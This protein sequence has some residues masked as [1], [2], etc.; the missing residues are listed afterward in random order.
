MP[1]K[2]KQSKPE[3]IKAK[4][5]RKIEAEKELEEAVLEP[6]VIERIVYKKPRV[7]GFFRTL[8]IL[9]LLAIGFLLLGE[10]MN[11]AKITVGNF[12]LDIIY[13]IFIIFSTIVIWCYK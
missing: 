10:T 5:T 1:S 13:P 9:A 7:H 12:A 4:K 6:Q 2:H 8:T 3:K 11:I